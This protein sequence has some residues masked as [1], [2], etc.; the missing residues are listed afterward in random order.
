MASASPNALRLYGVMDAD[1]SEH[2]SIEALKVSLVV[3]RDLGA[4]VAPARYIRA[5]QGDDELADYVRVIDAAY[6][7]GPVIPAPPGTI[8]RDARVLSHWM[9]IHYAKLHEALGVIERREN[10]N[11]PYDFVRMDLSA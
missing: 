7:L 1:D 6:K 8:F 10:P 5:K 4:I 9:E 11:P 2:G 3:L